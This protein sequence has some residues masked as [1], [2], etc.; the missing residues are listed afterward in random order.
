M[1]KKRTC[2]NIYFS[3]FEIVIFKDKSRGKKI[4]FYICDLFFTENRLSRLHYNLL[5]LQIIQKICVSHTHIYTHIYTRCYQKMQFSLYLRLTYLAV[6]YLTAKDKNYYVRYDCSLLQFASFL[7]WKHLISVSEISPEI[8]SRSLELSL[9]S[10]PSVCYV[11]DDK[12]LF[13][14]YKSSARE[15]GYHTN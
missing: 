14:L 11:C 1:L 2:K 12:Q 10:L 15:K 9:C 6:L 8:I 7:T 3:I 13:T 4:L 5:H